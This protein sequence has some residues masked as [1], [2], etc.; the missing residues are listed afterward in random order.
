MKRKAYIIGTLAAILLGNAVQ[1]TG[2]YSRIA[3]SAQNFQRYYRDL[4][5]GQNS[6]SP[7]ERVVF[8]LVLANSKSP[9]RTLASELPVG[10]S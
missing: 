7:I 3:N 1:S 6:L 8:S 9:E 10:R 4:Q 5:E 2:A